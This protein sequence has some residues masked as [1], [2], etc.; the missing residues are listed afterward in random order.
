MPAPSTAI[1]REHLE[2]R[3]GLAFHGCPPDT[4]VRL[5]DKKII[6]PKVCAR[7]AWLQ[8]PLLAPASHSL[9]SWVIYGLLGA[10]LVAAFAIVSGLR[11][12]A[13]LNLSFSNSVRFF[14]GPVEPLRINRL[15]LVRS[16][17]LRGLWDGDQSS[18]DAESTVWV[19][20]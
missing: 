11:V 7:P 4:E 5:K 9:S 6:C 1:P 12:Q 14:S 17:R 2:G 15:A 13:N 19:D 8:I 3:A 16:F 20:S 10:V 18:R